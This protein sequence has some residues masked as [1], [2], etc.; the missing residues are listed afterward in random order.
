MGKKTSRLNDT[1][2]VVG[3]PSFG[4]ELNE[5]NSVSV[6][7]IDNGYIVNKSSCRNGRYESSEQYSPTAPQLQDGENSSAMSKAVNYMK[8]EG[9]I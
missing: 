9:I 8:S 1:A 6:R 7:K 3:I 5:S 2:A 4:P